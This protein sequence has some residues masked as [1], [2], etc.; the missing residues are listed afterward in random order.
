MK[1][2]SPKIEIIG[3]LARE[4]E[5]KYR[6]LEALIAEIPKERVLPQL[7]AL[8]ERSTDRFRAAQ[9][10]LLD[11]PGLFEGE[12]ARTATLATT[13]LGSAFDEMRILFQ[14]LIENLPA[15]STQS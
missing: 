11:I 13:A 7:K 5:E 8:A 12:N 2:N 4:Y 1:N 15:D 3:Q 6:E 14:F 9:M 10:A